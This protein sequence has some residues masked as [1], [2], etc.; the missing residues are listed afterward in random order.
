MDDRVQIKT[1]NGIKV[2]FIDFSNLPTEDVLKMLPKMNEAAVSNK[3][4]LYILDAK[5]INMTGEGKSAVET[6]IK[7]IESKLGKTYSAIIGF[8]G[9]QKIIANAIN[10]D[11][12]FAKDY[13]D[14]VEWA[15][16]TSKK[17]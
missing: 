13:S 7:D 15:T 1:E 8:T 6:S 16:K 3:L 2:L 14:A 17:I 11:T 5:N 9:I 10:K 12:Y 4:V